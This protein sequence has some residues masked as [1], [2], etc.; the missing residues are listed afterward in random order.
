[1][2][3][4]EAKSSDLFQIMDLVI[5]AKAVSPYC[6]IPHDKDVM[7]GVIRR[8]MVNKLSCVLVAEASETLSGVIMGV[9]AELWYS[10]SKRTADPAIF[11]CTSKEYAPRL[12]EAYLEWAWSIKSVVEVTFNVASKYDPALEDSV[13]EEIGLEEVGH[14]WVALRPAQEKR[15]VVIL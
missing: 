6:D 7:G 15:D 11:Y 1:M 8:M 4:R 13:F 2:I 3:I 10:K 12:A 5:N 14:S 9:A